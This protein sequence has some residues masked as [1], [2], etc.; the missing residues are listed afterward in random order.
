M[1]EPTVTPDPARAP[2]SVVLPTRDRPEKLR[3]CLES[4]FAALREGDEVIVVDSAS[5]DPEVA[6]VATAA[7]AVVVRCDRPGVDR[8]RNAGWRRTGHDAVLFVDDDV[9][10]DAGWAD[11]LVAALA[12]DPPAG[13]VTGRIDALP[14]GHSMER[15]VAIKDDDE[16]ARLDA[17]STGTLGHSASLAV[18]RAALED[19]GGFDEAMGAGARFQ[20]SPEVDL[21]DRLFAAGW[22]GRYEPAARAWHE[23]WRG[24][25]ELLKLDW[26]YGMG[27]GAR[28]AKL[29]RT[30]RPRARRIA[31]EVFWAT[32][33][34]TAW[35]DL[36][37]R[38][39]TGVLLRLA[40]VVGAVVGFAAALPVPVRDGHYRP[41]RERPTSP[42]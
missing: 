33:L 21:F 37:A 36:R 29:V 1:A 2:C 11:A 5:V 9:V 18:R 31:A 15:P 28:L 14:G 35:R 10:V 41:R 13:F 20:S 22:V 26:R 3:R 17:S 32:G 23:Q 4:V 38:Y 30:D 16:A 34:R 24:R 12:S 39:K 6:R 8:A 27:A 25:S 19:V 42:S 7:G 40:Q